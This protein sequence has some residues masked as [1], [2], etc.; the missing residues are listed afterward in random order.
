M[1]HM[2]RPGEIPTDVTEFRSRYQGGIGS[3]GGRGPR[4]KLGCG[5][6]VVIAIAIVILLTWVVIP[7]LR[8]L[9]GW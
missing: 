1:E 9:L 8:M 6:Q 4:I 3:G 7:L 5:W 2:P